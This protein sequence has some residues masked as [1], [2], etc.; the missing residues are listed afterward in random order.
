MIDFKTGN[1][2]ALIIAVVVSAA[3]IS[4]Q[5]ASYRKEQISQIKILNETPTDTF[6]EIKNV[7]VPNFIE[8]ENPFIVYD[9]Q[10]KKTFT[11]YWNVE[12]HMLAGSTDYN[13]C[14]GSGSAL[15]TPKETLPK[16]GVSLEWFIGKDCHLTAGQWV[17][18]ANWEIHAEGY[19]PKFQTY[20]SNIFTVLPKG[21]Q[22]FVT[23]EQSA[24]IMKG[25]SP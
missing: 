19:P 14:S 11:G 3:G 10:I 21:S 22:L 7:S 9:R 18:Q 5:Q 20:T 6:F 15:Y 8:G 23:P 13:Y 25:N 1:F 16:V 2:R 12:A 4:W 17:L 24:K